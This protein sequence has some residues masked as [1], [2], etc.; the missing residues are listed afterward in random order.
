MPRYAWGAPGP[1][2]AD[3]HFSHCCDPGSFS[4]SCALVTH[5][6]LASSFRLPGS[7]D[8]EISGPRGPTVLQG[9]PAA[10]HCISPEH[11]CVSKYLPRA[12][13][14]SSVP[15]QARMPGIIPKG[16]PHLREEPR[17]CLLWEWEHNPHSRGHLMTVSK[18]S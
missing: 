15:P 14:L 18:P 4:L 7:P 6:F 3:G 2:L 1:H 9:L 13:V 17:V 12:A 10:H 8:G 5:S 16:C 11:H